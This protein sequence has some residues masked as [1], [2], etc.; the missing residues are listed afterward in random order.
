MSFE[1]STAQIN[2]YR[3]EWQKLLEQRDQ[4]DL[5]KALLAKKIRDQMPAGSAGNQMFLDFL[6]AEKLPRCS[7]HVMLTKALSW[8]IFEEKDWKK[9]SGWSGISFLYNLSAPER[10][11]V[12]KRCTADGS[13]TRTKLKE[14]AISLEI[15]LPSSGLGRPTNEKVFHGREVLAQYLLKLHKLYPHVLPPIP[16]NVRSELT[17]GQRA[18]LPARA[19]ARS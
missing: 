6:R 7:P 4:N 17:T 19:A 15:E 14:I 18:K 11:M 16:A 3:A 12:M 8:E 13:Y 10:K 9:F 1:M 2:S 5:G